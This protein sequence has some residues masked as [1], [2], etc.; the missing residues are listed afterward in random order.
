MSQESSARDFE[1]YLQEKHAWQYSGTDDCMPD[2]YADWL[3]YLD[4]NDV[5]KW[6]NEYVEIQVKKIK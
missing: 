5:I 1:S 2:D 6:A 4:I 3:S